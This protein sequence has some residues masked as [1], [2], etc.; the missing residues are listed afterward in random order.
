M[1]PLGEKKHD[2]RQHG[3]HFW[4]SKISLSN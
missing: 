2:Q 4:L 3:W 1:M